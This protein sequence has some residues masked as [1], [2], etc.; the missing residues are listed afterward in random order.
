MLRGVRSA[1][2]RLN[3]IALLALFVAL[4]TGGAYAAAKITS[5]QIRDGTIKERDLGSALR[6]RLDQAGA[7]GPQGVTGP[8]GV[9]GTRGDSGATG[10]TGPPGTDASLPTTL[11]SG[12]TLRGGFVASGL[13]ASAGDTFEA[14]VSFSVSLASAPT[15][16]V[17][18]PG[19]S[20][21]AACTGTAADPA[22]AAGHLCV[23]VATVTA[24]TGAVTT[25]DPTETRAAGA[26]KASRLAF[27]VG[28][29]ASGAGDVRAAGTWAVTAP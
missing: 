13:A 3:P 8:A 21:P 22:A 2:Q 25:Y 1:W 19:G 20:P 5:R 12:R 10:P 29:T 15:V 11:P 24:S 28:V 9:A 27:D 7:P 26:G 16:H 18:L 23:Y 17:I 4:G 14:G 6:A